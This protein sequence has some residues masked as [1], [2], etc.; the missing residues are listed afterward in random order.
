MIHPELDLAAEFP[1]ADRAVWRD[2]VEKV[3]RGRN[4]DSV[5]VSETCGG[6]EIQP[7]YTADDPVAGESGPGVDSGSVGLDPDRVS[8]GWD[9]RQRH[10]GA[11]AAR[12]NQEILEDLDRG[13][14]SVELEIPADADGDSYLA[15]GIEGV[16]LDVT[17]VAL[18]PHCLVERARSLLVLADGAGG[19]GGGCCWLGLDP[20]GGVACGEQLDRLDQ[21]LVAAA[22]FAADARSGLGGAR[23]FTV[24][25]TRYADAGATEP[26]QLA[27]ALS[28]GVA[29]LRAC[30]QVGIAPGEAASLIGFR[31]DATADQFATIA[32]LRAARRVW[33]RV[34]QACGVPLEGRRQAQQAVTSAAMYSRRDPWVNL[35]RATTAALAAGVA[36]ADSVTVLPFDSALGEPDPLGRRMA[37]NT[38][39]LLIQE[40]HLSR[41]VDPAAGSWFVESL[42]GRL[43]E[44][45]WSGLQSIESAGGMAAVLADGSLEAEV[46]ASWVSRLARLS[47]RRDPLTGVSEFPLPDEE[48]LPRLELPARPGWPI[49]R[50]AKPFEDLRD[51]SDRHLAEHGSRPK[52]FVATLGDLADHTARTAWVTNLLAVAGIAVVGA[53]SRGADSRGADSHDADSPA[54]VSAG[55]TASGCDIAV[56]CSSDVIYAERAAATAVALRQAD[57]VMVAIVGAPGDWRDELEAAGV[58][59]FWY[60]G[61]DVLDMLRQ[62]LSYLVG[63]DNTA[64]DN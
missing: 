20:I 37:R 49:R 14:T 17:P 1:P 53:D 25:V 59:Q 57:A 21:R 11:D 56:I 50:L 18:A 45:A 36:G 13:V 43:A 40:S 30:E 6:L 64:D 10:G 42:T 22:E 26:Q 62:L 9:V 44:M 47:T 16:M 2:A 34:L 58:S 8:H 54:E 28:T 32:T 5:L 23:V 3:L 38:Q 41:L 19:R 27:I 29:Y 60:E 4:F 63:A 52:V 33:A 31:F 7:L 39:A 61:I 35:L 46:T 24:D 55:L 12:R 15:A 48:L 51:A